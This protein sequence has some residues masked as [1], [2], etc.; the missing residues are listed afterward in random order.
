M[1]VVSL[2][3]VLC[4]IVLPVSAAGVI[5]PS[6]ESESYWCRWYYTG[7]IC[8]IFGGGSS[9]SVTNNYPVANDG[10]LINIYNVTSTFL[11]NTADIIN[12]YEGEGMNQTPNMT[13]G[14]Q[15]PQGPQGINGTPGEKGDKGDDGIT[16]DTSQFPFLNGS[17]VLTG[18]WDFGGYNL[19]NLLDPTQPQDAATK[20]Y[21]DDNAGSNYNASYWTGTNYNASYWTGT[22]YNSSYW[23]GSNYNSSYLTSTFNATYDA[24]NN[25]NASYWTGTNYNASYLTST[26]N[27]TYDAKTNY[28]S[29][30][31]NITQYAYLT[32]L[33]GSVMYPTTNPP[34]DFNQMETSGQ[35]NNFIYA[36]I[37]NVL[38]QNVQW[39]V[40]MPQDWN[41]ANTI[42]AQFLWTVQSG[43]GNLNWTLSGVRIE[44]DVALDTAVPL[45]TYKVDTVITANDLHVSD[46]TAATVV[47]GTGNL[48]VF[49][50]GR[51][52]SSDTLGAVPAQLMGVRLKYVKLI[53]A[54]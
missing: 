6:V 52:T 15:G 2:L 10:T 28:N 44:N 35:K 53:G 16:P 43:S 12:I 33:A 30:Y 8:D 21:V 7:W 9:V 48:I 36:N 47:T 1:R 27:S 18:I 24:K 29:S 3:L 14:P 23:V 22:N 25:Y 19:S 54:A 41:S 26:Y 17:R 42:I 20:K 50:V 13:A 32:L 34:S 5:N 49:K 40:D 11:N 46:A 38:T 39:I 45:I 51:S 4:F 31:A 37:T